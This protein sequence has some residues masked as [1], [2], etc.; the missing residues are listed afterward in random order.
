MA[1]GRG[2]V[3]GPR[4]VSHKSQ[5]WYNAI[6]DAHIARLEAQA[7]QAARS[8]D[9]TGA[10]VSPPENDPDSHAR[11]AGLPCLQV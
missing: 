8:G 3:R 5:Q 10:T 1:Y 4:K 6:A 9:G 7:Q 2:H 11:K